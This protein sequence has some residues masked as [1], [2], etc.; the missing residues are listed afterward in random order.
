MNS[1][2]KSIRSYVWLNG[3]VY[4]DIIYK[5][6]KVRT[7]NIEEAPDTAKRFCITSRKKTELYDP[8]YKRTETVYEEGR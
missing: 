1:K 8:V 7:V 4:L 5:S 3:G 2:I 6:G